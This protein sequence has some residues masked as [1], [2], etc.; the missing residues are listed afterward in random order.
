MQSQLCSYTRPMQI[1]PSD[2]VSNTFPCPVPSWLPA[3][4]TWR[5]PGSLLLC[6]PRI[7]SLE[8]CWAGSALPTQC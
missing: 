4:S 8:P 2:N 1:L 6:Q 5:S 3:Q 7:L